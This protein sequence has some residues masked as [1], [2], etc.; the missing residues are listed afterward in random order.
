[1]KVIEESE[2]F[3]L[4]FNIKKTKIMASGAITSLQKG[5]TEDVVVGWYRQL[6]GHEFEYT[7]RVG[8]GQRSLVCCSPWG[9]RVRLDWGTEL[10]DDILFKSFVSGHLGCFHVLVIVNSAATNIGVPVISLNCHFC[11]D[12]CQTKIF[13]FSF[14]RNLHTLFHS[15]CNNLHAINIMRILISLIDKERSL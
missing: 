4:K 9:C 1:M 15:G 7:S 3:A 5:T 2:K 11:L 8:D 14:L 13:S 6:N 10:I 12:I